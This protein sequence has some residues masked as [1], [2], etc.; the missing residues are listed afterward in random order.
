VI[1]NDFMPGRALG[2]SDGD[3]IVAVVNRRQQAFPLVVATRGWHS[4]WHAIFASSY[5]G[6]SP[7]GSIELDG[8]EP[9][10]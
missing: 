9:T 10:L 1:Q 5:P 2:G 4:P 7:F 8:L 3:A 6:S